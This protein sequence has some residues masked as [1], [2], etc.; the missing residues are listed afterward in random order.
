MTPTHMYPGHP[1]SISITSEQKKLI[2]QYA[3]N[4]VGCRGVACGLCI[5]SKEVSEGKFT[6]CREIVYGY[7]AASSCNE[8]T[9]MRACQAVIIA[10]PELFTPEEVAE[11]F[12]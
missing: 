4:D 10:E 2:L 5:L 9:V 7:T 11:V 8:V 1:N 12:L 3:S 6:L